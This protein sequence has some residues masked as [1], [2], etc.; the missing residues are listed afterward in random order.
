MFWNSVSSAGQIFLKHQ[1]LIK[2]C[3][4]TKFDR[5]QF[6]YDYNNSQRSF[7]DWPVVG[8]VFHQ[9]QQGSPLRRQASWQTRRSAFGNFHWMMSLRLRRQAYILRFCKKPQRFETTFSSYSTRF[10]TTERC[11]QVTYEPT[12]DP[13]DSAFNWWCD[14]MS[15]PNISGPYCRC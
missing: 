11:T 5:R 14:T 15:S 1:T 6:L 4:Y 7:L 8:L 9:R 2:C 12:I 13:S 3:K 10:D